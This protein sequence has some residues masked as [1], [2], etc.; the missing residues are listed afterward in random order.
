MS[1][2]IWNMKFLSG[3]EIQGQRV[4]IQNDEYNVPRVVKIPFTVEDADIQP[5]KGSSL[6]ALPEGL[7]SDIEYQIYTPTPLSSGVEGTDIRP[8][9]LFIYGEWFVVVSVSGWK[10]SLDENYLAFVKRETLR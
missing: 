3:V 5:I 6:M 2:S 7:R 4:R 10:N 1:R 9:M 8:D